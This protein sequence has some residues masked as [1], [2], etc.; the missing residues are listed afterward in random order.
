M[1]PGE[2]G[3]GQVKESGRYQKCPPEGVHCRIKLLV[4]TKT[5][6]GGQLSC[7][8]SQ[9]V[10]WQH[11]QEQRAKVA[12]TELCGGSNTCQLQL[13]LCGFFACNGDQP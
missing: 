13:Q 7:N 12:R 9:P 1:G 10:A 3:L 5:L 11:V 2:Q 8:L 6:S 4:I